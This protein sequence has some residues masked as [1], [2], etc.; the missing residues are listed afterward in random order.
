MILVTIDIIVTSILIQTHMEQWCTGGITHAQ[1]R[2]RTKYQ[3]EVYPKIRFYNI[4]KHKNTD[5]I[6]RCKNISIQT[7]L[8]DAQKYQ[9]K[10]RYNAGV[11]S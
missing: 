4:H 3:D 5:T 7:L 1:E 8:Y 9:Y 6:I 11:V 2:Y 10:H